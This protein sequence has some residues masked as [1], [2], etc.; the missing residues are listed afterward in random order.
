MTEQLSL[1]AALAMLLA[2]AWSDIRAFRIANY[3]PFA[4]IL[5]FA[6][7]A[8]L[9]VAPGV[10]WWHLAHFAIALAVGMLVFGIKWIGGGDAKLYAAIAIW[11]PLATGP[12][13]LLCITISGAVVALFYIAMRKFGVGPN[14]DLARKDR[15]IPYGVALAVGAVACW[16]LQP[17][18]TPQGKTFDDLTAKTFDKD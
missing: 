12:L 9:D 18:I 1:A 14:A 3:Y 17:V 16:F 5:I 8:L 4:L 15:R 13:L 6:A 11:F 2:A 7:Y 10:P